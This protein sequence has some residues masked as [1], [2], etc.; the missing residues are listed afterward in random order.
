[1]GGR[2]GREESPG[3]IPRRR[4]RIAA[5]CHA[6]RRTPSS[7]CRRCRPSGRRGAVPRGALG[8]VG[9][10]AVRRR[11]PGRGAGP[12]HRLR[13]LFREELGVEPSAAIG[14]LELAILQQDTALDLAPAVS[15]D[16]RC[17]WRGLLPYQS[18]DSADFF[19]REV[20]IEACLDRLLARGRLVVVGRSGCGK[21]SLVRA[22]LVPRLAGR[23][24]PA[25]IVTPGPHPLDAL[26]GTDEVTVLVVDQAEELITQCAD[27]SER[28]EFFDRLVR[29]AGRVVVVALADLMDEL[30]TYRG[31]GELLDAVCSCFGRSMRRGSA[32][33]SRCQPSAPP[34]D[35]NR[36]WSSCS[37]RSAAT[38]RRPPA[39]VA[40]TR[41]DVAAGGG[42]HAHRR[43]VQQLGRDPRRDRQ[44]RRAR[45][46]VVE[47]RSATAHAAVV[48][49]ARPIRR[50][51]ARAGSCRAGSPMTTSSSD[52][53]PPGC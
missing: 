22:G 50:G 6:A 48:P 53:S 10:G 43:R 31:F 37:S 25:V 24:A 3:G 27:G 1:M 41:R 13:R 46:R 29:R 8:V 30:T 36:A 42:Q 51:P 21:S 19:G 16:A 40:R 15:D 4:R 11:S 20:E 9:Q 33:L 5:R 35:S 2:R 14:A 28:R 12:L 32:P 17:P 49:A 18:D 44:L 26:I 52:C 23:G 38:S 47:R 39:A 34:S 45:L 7:R